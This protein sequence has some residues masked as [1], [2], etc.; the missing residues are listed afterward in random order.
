MNDGFTLTKEL[1][2]EICLAIENK[3]SRRHVPRHVFAIGDIPYTVNGKKC[4]INVKQI[5]SGMKT[6]VSGTVA[7]PECLELYAR[8][9]WLQPDG[10]IGS[11]AVARL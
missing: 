10:S 9:L 5:V 8:Y 6:G 1:I 11:P 3:Y 4:E 7:N 2:V